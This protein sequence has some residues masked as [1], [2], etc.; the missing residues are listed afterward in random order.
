MERKEG[1]YNPQRVENV[2]SSMANSEKIR[3]RRM[4]VNIFK[5]NYQRFKKEGLKNIDLYKGDFKPMPQSPSLDSSSQLKIMLPSD[6]FMPIEY[7][8]F[9]ARFIKV[10]SRDLDDIDL[11]IGGA[12]E[13]P[14]PKTAALKNFIKNKPGEKL[15]FTYAF[16]PLESDFFDEK[17]IVVKR[18]YE[19]LKILRP[20]TEIWTAVKLPKF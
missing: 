14:E 20:I 10:F 12:S 1:E 6:F 9:Y 11:E 17:R 5:K 3:I 4:T 18:Y 8:E 16:Y 15:T 19:D 7:E 2:K 13:I